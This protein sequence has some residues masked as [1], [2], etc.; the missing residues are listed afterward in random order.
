M[1]MKGK[2]LEAPQKPSLKEWLLDK[3]DIEKSAKMNPLTELAVGALV[4]GLGGVVVG[5]PVGY[6]NPGGLHGR[7]LTHKERIQSAKLMSVA[8]GSLGVL[9]GLSSVRKRQF[10][11]EQAKRFEEAWRAGRK[12]KSSRPFSVV[13][14]WIGKPAT[15]NEAKKK[16]RSEAM[17]RH[18]DKGGSEEAM[19]LLNYEW[20]TFK[21]SPRFEKLAAVTST[22]FLDE[23]EKIASLEGLVLSQLIRRKVGPPV[24]SAVEELEDRTRK[25][26][27]SLT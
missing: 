1:N 8:L 13:P 17:K 21:N 20:D 24:M 22:A 26:W 27:Q 10:F 14:P 9:T 18:P 5:A 4:G 6:A 25:R 19:K 15:K 7:K 11:R 12:Y 16:F 23:L 3:G 2:N